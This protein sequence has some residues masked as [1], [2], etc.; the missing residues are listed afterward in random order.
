MKSYTVKLVRDKLAKDLGTMDLSF[1]PVESFEE[2]VLLLRG[3]LMEEAT[4]Y[5]LKPGAGEL[6]DV[7]EAVRAL[8]SVDLGTSMGVIE[9][10]R[11]AKYGARGGFL[12]GTVMVSTTR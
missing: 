1:K 10:I 11:S 12:G 2:H 5:L 3:K 4:E 7:L 8:A 6:A 9:D